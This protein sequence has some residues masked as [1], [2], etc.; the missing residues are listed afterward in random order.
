[1]RKNRYI[2]DKDRK[3]ARRRLSILEAMQDPATIDY[4]QRI[5]VAKGWHCLEVGGG[6]GSIAA[7][8]CDRVTSTGRVVATD[9]DTGFLEGLEFSQL[10][11]VEHNAAMDTFENEA[12]DIVHARDLLVHIPERET[13]LGNLVAA[14]K[15]GGWILIEDPDV[16][17]DAPDPT[18]PKSARQ[19]YRTVTE[20]IYAFLRESGLD[21]NFGAR[22]FGLLRSLGFSL[23]HSEGRVRMFRGGA[24][25][26]ARSPHMLAFEQLLDP[27][28]AAGRVTEREFRDFLA[29]AEDPAFAWRE[30]L[31]MSTW[32]QRPAKPARRK[33]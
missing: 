14:V 7:W 16:V 13:V 20:A 24:A 26:D 2:L 33:R 15:P 27:V 18:A 11:I 6:G 4:L 23:L 28:V 19:L 9:I 8:L 30:G 21:P 22:V 12:F 25:A 17:T 31:T 29:L 3:E 10:E 1:M 32:G 5:G